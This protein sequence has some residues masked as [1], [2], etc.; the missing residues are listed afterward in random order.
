MWAQ[1]RHLNR[2]QNRRRIHF[3]HMNRRRDLEESGIGGEL[4]VG[5]RGR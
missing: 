1:I 3:W 4:A 2:T 5:L